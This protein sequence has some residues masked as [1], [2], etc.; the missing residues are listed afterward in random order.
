M[1]SNAFNFKSFTVREKAGVG[2]KG[3][4][5][6]FVKESRVAKYLGSGEARRF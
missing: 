6:G 3:P 4:T 2:L 5:H 1:L